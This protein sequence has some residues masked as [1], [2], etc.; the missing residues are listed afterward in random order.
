MPVTVTA[1]NLANASSRKLVRPEASL[2]LAF[3]HPSPIKPRAFVTV[4]CLEIFFSRHY[5]NGDSA[6][7]VSFGQWR[8][9]TFGRSAQSSAAKKERKNDEGGKKA[10]GAADTNVCIHNGARY[11][12][13]VP[14]EAESTRVTICRALR[15]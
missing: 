4:Q 7:V 8:L 1:H 6:V 11:S 5:S 10:N 15:V 2:T 13:A 14:D 12:A 3:L 9:P